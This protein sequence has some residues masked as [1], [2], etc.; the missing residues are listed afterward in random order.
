MRN[1][2]ASLA[3]SLRGASRAQ[4]LRLLRACAQNL[5]RA[6]FAKN[7]GQAWRKLPLLRGGLR[8][9]PFSELWK[10]SSQDKQ[11]AGRHAAHYEQPASLAQLLGR[12]WQD[13]EREGHCSCRQR[14]DGNG[15]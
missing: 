6:E 13:K 12:W 8:W 10:S 1:R 11:E 15:D 9:K 5:R 7:S 2:C 14:C 3:P 4:N